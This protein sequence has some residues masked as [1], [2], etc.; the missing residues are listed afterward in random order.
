MKIKSIS[1]VVY[2]V[3]DLDSETQVDN[4]QV[5]WYN[6]NEERRDK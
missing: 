6:S 2:F 1:G 3:K 4:Y 5:N